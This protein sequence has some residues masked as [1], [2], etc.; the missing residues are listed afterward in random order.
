MSKAT[1][2]VSDSADFSANPVGFIDTNPIPADALGDLQVLSVT[3]RSAK[4]CSLDRVQGGFIPALNLLDEDS[5]FDAQKFSCVDRQTGIVFPEWPSI[6]Y[7]N[8][9][10][11]FFATKKGA[12]VKFCT[13]DSRSFA[14]NSSSSDGLYI[15][16]NSGGFLASIV[17]LDGAYG[18]LVERSIASEDTVLAAFVYDPAAGDNGQAVISVP[19]QGSHTM[20]NMQAKDTPSPGSNPDA[21]VSLLREPSESSTGDQLREIS[22]VAQYDKPM[23]QSEIEAIYQAYK[24]WLAE[25]GVTVV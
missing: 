22:F 10:T 23:T 9:F 2:V 5:S 3:T 25:L 11:L 14:F 13:G 18:R 4:V 7:E 8:G 16:G 12:G 19:G 15:Y 1:V 20:F 6:N 17:S 24:P 21:E